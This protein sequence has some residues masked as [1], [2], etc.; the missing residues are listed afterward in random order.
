MLMV[1]LL[2]LQLLLLVHLLLLQQAP[3]HPAFKLEHPMFTLLLT[4]MAA[5]LLMLQA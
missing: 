5:A 1:L 3:E 4:L 2:F